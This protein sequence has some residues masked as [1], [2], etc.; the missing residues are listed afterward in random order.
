MKIHIK[1]PTR[2]LSCIDHIVSNIENASA[3]VLHLGLSD[4]ETAQIINFPVVNKK[5]KPRVH[6]IFK[7]D[8]SIEN[9]MKFKNAS[10]KF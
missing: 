1:E 9:I 7:R 8:Y 10:I 4:H 5:Q 3:S 6:Y 2:R